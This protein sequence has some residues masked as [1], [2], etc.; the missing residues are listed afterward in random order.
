MAVNGKALAMAVG[1]GVLLW[2]GLTSPKGNPR[3]VLAALLAGKA[4]ARPSSQPGFTVSAGGGQVGAGSPAG[5]ATGSAIADDA[6]KYKGAGYVWGG[7]PAKGTGN[8][9]CSS[10]VNWVLGHDLG[11]A[12]PGFKTYDG[13]SHGPNTLSYLAWAGAT[14]VGHNGADAQPGDLCVWQ[15]H[16]GIAIGN[17]QMISARDPQEGTGID[18]IQGDIPGEILY[19]RRLRAA[20]AAGSSADAAPSGIGAKLGQ[21]GI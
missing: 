8:W 10:F 9:D 6:L 4:P 15:T 12:I 20:G 1:G 13:S 21:G 18:T 7:A 17:G 2:T 16:M 3:D 5:S 11:L 19:I 14:T